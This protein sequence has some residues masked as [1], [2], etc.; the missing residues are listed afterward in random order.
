MKQSCGYGGKGEARRARPAGSC[1]GERRAAAREPDRQPGQHPAHRER[2]ASRS[3]VEAGDGG[4]GRSRA[5][6]TGGADGVVTADN[7][8][9]DAGPG[10]GR[11]PEAPAQTPPPRRL[12]SAESAM[13]PQQTAPGSGRLAHRPTRSGEFGGKST[14]TCYSTT[15]HD[16]DELQYKLQHCEPQ[17]AKIHHVTGPRRIKGFLSIRAIGGIQTETTKMSE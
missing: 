13:W 9:Q 14:F 5:V 16:P 3:T 8:P 17:K 7:R 2:A 11:G 15:E 4:G 1:R 10:T 6:G 12:F